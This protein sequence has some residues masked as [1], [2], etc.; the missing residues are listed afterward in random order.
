MAEPLLFDLQVTPEVWTIQGP[1]SPPHQVASPLAD[2][3]FRGLVASL[4]EWAGRPV[5]LARPDP[6]RTAEFVERRARRVS[7]RLSEVLLDEGDRRSVVQALE[8]GVRARL[9]IRPPHCA[10]RGDR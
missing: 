5:P 8:D 3:R 7:A 6:L 2:A 10:A 4:R 1:A 9:A